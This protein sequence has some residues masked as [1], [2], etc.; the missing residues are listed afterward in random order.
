M[1]L[2][3]IGLLSNKIIA[4]IAQTLVDTFISL[5]PPRCNGK[6]LMVTN[7]EDESTYWLYF[8]YHA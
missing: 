6:Q 5:R 8:I 3:K 2:R 7:I 1:T 4:E